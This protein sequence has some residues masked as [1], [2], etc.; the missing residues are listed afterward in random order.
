[1]TTL[2]EEESGAKRVLQK[3]SNRSW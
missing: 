2:N 1:M 3:H